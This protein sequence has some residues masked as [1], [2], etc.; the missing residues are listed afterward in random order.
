M[1]KAVI[2]DMDGLMFDTEVVYK[3]AWTQAAAK[4]GY[5][6][7]DEKHSYL[8]G[9][10]GVMQKGHFIRWYGGDVPFD[11]IKADCRAY[12]VEYLST[13]EIPIKAG[14]FELLNALKEKGYKIAVATGTQRHNAIRWWK[15]AGVF[16]Y[17]DVGVGGD[18][19]SKG[20]PDPEIFLLTV[21]RLGLQAEE[22][23]V[24]EDSFNGIRAEKA[25]GCS[26]VMIPDMEQPTEEIRT[27]CDHV[28]P[29][30][31][32]VIFVL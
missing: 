21:E 6:L 22:C 18:E 2:F 25:A 15:K 32:E 17:I 30:L 31:A 26:P 27:L 9:S 7:D 19:V 10:N 8:R 13:H 29:S 24:L 28:F 5:H 12:M 4:R 1:I 16:D 3:I 23:M 11:E 14:L 20:K